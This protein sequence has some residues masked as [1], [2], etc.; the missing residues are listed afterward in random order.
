MLVGCKGAV[1]GGGEVKSLMEQLRGESLKFHKPGEKKPREQFDAFA[2]LLVSL[3]FFILHVEQFKILTLR[4]LIFSS[5]A[6]I[7]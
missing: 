6:L 2:F 4:M 1:D 7:T 5:L 3:F